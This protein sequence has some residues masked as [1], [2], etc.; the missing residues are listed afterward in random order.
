MLDCPP[1]SPIHSIDSEAMSSEEYLEMLRQ[2][3]LLRLDFLADVFT[4]L[5]DMPLYQPDDGLS[6]RARDA[7]HIREYFRKARSDLGL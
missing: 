3:E 7:N 1:I 5:D 2:R 4:L 6:G